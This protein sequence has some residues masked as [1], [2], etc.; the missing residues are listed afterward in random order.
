M[1]G[2]EQILKK[3]LTIPSRKERQRERERE[4][5]Q[6]LSAITMWHV[7]YGKR[8]GER[9]PNRGRKR[10]RR[11]RKVLPE[12]CTCMRLRDKKLY[13]PPFFFKQLCL[14]CPNWISSMGNL[15]CILQGK[16]AATVALP[17]LRCQLG[18]FQCFHNPLS[19]FMDYRFFNMHTNV[20]AYNCTQG[21]MDTLRESA[22]KVDSGRKNPVVHIV[23]KPASMA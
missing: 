23:I 19:S 14:C 18:V 6:R 15:C 12:I 20:N 21:C 13:P 2:D 10:T 22:L 16:S 9:E 17:N 5:M 7:G 1:G 4:R 11:R 3:L 8:E